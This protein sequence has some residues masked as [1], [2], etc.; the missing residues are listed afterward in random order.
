MPIF[1]RE[2]ISLAALGLFLL[3]ASAWADI[4]SAGAL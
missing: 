3:S 1:V 4:V 2:F